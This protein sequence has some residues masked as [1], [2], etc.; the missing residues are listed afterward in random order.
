[1]SSTKNLFLSINII[2]NG[3]IKDLKKASFP[4]FFKGV[5]VRV[6]I[7]FGKEFF[8]VAQVIIKN[9]S[10]Y[11]LD[12]IK[13]KI[14]EGMELLGGWERFLSPGMTVLLKVNLIGPKTSDTAAITHSEFVRALTQ[15]LKKR[16]CIV[17]IGDSSGGAIGG[18]APTAKSFVVSGLEKVAREEGALIKNFDKEGVVEVNPQSGYIDKMYLAKPMFDADFVINLPKLKTHSAGIYTGAVKNLFGCIPGLRKAEYHRL[19]PHQKDLG[20]MIVDIH[21]S[22]KVGLHIMDGITAMQGEGPTAGKVYPAGKILFSTDPLAL[23]TVA[24]SMMGMNI[25]DIPILISARERKLGESD[26]DKIELAGDY[27][28]PPLLKGFR[29]PKKFRSDRLHKDTNHKILVKVI[30]FLKVRPRINTKVCKNCNVC[31][32]SC[33]VKA[34]NKETKTIDYSSCIECMC[35]HELCLHKA[36][37]LKNDNPLAGFISRFYRGKYK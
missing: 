5:N 10:E 32:E 21:H 27:T 37:D 24:S 28:V 25:E 16:G 17:W 20:Q 12:L 34:I 8:T 33:P 2:Y 18:V 7:D 35:C 1:L 4:S 15:I 13:G 19:A 36:V 29:L 6:T 9:C 3:Y 26:L 23:D 31:V 22:V 30:D 11:R 14:E